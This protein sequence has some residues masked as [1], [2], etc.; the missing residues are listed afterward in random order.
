MVAELVE[1]QKDIEARGA[2]LAFVHLSTED[3]AKTFFGPY[4]LLADAAV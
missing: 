2:K 3:K 1:K 4:G